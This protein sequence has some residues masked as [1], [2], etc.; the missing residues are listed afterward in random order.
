MAHISLHLHLPLLSPPGSQN[1]SSRN[2]EIWN[3][4]SQ[5]HPFLLERTFSLWEPP[6]HV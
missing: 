3:N 5:S 4:I 6:S 1:G 2:A